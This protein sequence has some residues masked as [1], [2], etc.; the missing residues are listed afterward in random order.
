MTGSTIARQHL[1]EIAALLGVDP[2]AFL[3]P[4]GPLLPHQDTI[5][6]LDLWTRLGCPDA[7]RRVLGHLLEEVERFTLV[8]Q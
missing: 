6:L 8:Q 5:A 4:G 2:S 7:R 3:D 1:E